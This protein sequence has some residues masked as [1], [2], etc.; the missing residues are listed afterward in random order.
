MDTSS[1]R[2]LLKEIDPRIESVADDESLLERGIIDSLTM[3]DLLMRLEERYDV[4]I[5]DDELM[6]ENF[7][8]LRAIA[9]FLALKRES[10]GKGE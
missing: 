5:E 6:P 4:T 10:G 1:I 7:E 2:R 8:S 9:S 3:Q